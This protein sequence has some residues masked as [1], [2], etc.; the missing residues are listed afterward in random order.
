L[1]CSYDSDQDDNTAANKRGLVDSDDETDEDTAPP[2]GD[3]L[4]VTSG[5]PR[6]PPQK[7]AASISGGENR[8]PGTDDE[9][10]KGALKVSLQPPGTAPIP[11]RHIPHEALTVE[12]RVQRMIQ[13]SKRSKIEGER[14]ERLE[15]RKSSA[16]SIKM[17]YL[18]LKV[19]GRY[20]F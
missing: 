8:P 11:L 2:G 14:K 10:K 15:L 18:Q 4:A 12:Q 20:I 16:M 13:E 3:A 19:R 7:V 9:P 5:A 17:L 1:F 6:P